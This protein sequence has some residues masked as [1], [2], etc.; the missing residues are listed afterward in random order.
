MSVLCLI[1]STTL[2]ALAGCSAR[3]SSVVTRLNTN[4][5]L[6]SDIPVDP[7]QWRVITTGVDP[8]SSTRFAL[9]GNDAAIRYSRSSNARNYPD[10]SVLALITW[11]QQEDSRWF[12]GKISS[13]AKSVEFV[14][15]RTSQDG[16]PSNYYRAYEGLPLKEISSP[17]NEADGRAHIF[18]RWAPPFTLET[19]ILK[20]R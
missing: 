1:V 13:H 8:R 10:G 18:F 12:G 6:T 19:A 15:V 9:F 4:A 14:D 3:N 5:A 16:S 2:L 17:K 7:L 20:V 11:Q